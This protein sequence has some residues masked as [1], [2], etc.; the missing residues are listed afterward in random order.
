[1]T[2]T[3][4]GSICAQFR[5]SGGSGSTLA[6][7]SRC[8]VTHSAF[9]VL[10]RLFG[11][12]T[13]GYHLVNISLHATAAFLFRRHSPETGCARRRA[14][15]IHLCPASGARR[16]GSVD[17]RVEEHAL[18]RVLSRRGPGLSAIRH[19][20]TE[21]IVCAGACPLPRLP[22]SARRSRPRCPQRCS[23][24]S[25]GSAVSCARQDVLPLLPFFA[26]GVIGGAVTSWVERTHIGAEGAAFGFSILERSLIAGR[27]IWFYLSRNSSGRRTLVF[28]YPRWTIDSLAWWQYAFPT[29]CRPSAG[30][31]VVV[32]DA[33]PRP[34]GRSAVVHRDAGACAGFCQ[35][36]PV[37]FFLRGRP[38]SVLRPASESSRSCRPARRC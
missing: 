6:P 13:L 11:E 35:R 12:A 10:H 29:G 28:I 25:G 3:L 24:C 32:S 37:R 15:G 36:L 21:A 26:L 23:S 19:G 27:A 8:A 5:G 34:V 14:G 30:R 38:F 2:P 22:C 4:R 1:M 9:W 31:V 17:H 16:V 33:I 20:S 18:G 7:R